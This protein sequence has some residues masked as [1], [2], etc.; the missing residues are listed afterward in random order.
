MLEQENRN[1]WN[2]IINYVKE[3]FGD[4]EEPDLDVI[5]FL[6][7]VRELGTPPQKKTFKKDQKLELMH[8]AIC[9][10]LSS[11]GYYQLDGLDEE[12]WP[13]YTL[14]KK[15][16]FLKPGEQS[17]LMKEAVIRYFDEEVWEDSWDN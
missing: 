13:H 4:G 12:G 17:V 16:P 5:L 1:K 10:L 14:L 8:I 15:L 6:I 11:Y 9:R 7:G 3:R 2:R